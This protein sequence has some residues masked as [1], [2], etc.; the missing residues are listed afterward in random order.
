MNIV[1]LEPNNPVLVSLSSP[2]GKIIWEGNVPIEI[3][4]QLTDG[5][6]LHV[7]MEVAPSILNLG[8]FE[9]EHFFICRYHS[10][11]R[12]VKDRINVWLTNEGEKMRAKLERE[13]SS[14]NGPDSQLE[15]QLAGSLQQA[16]ERK[17]PAA[18]APTPITVAPK[19]PAS[20]TVPAA[21]APLYARILGDTKQLLNVYSEA[22]VHAESL[23]VPAGVVRSLMLSAYISANQRGGRAA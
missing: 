21:L 7:P 15:R 14:A 18:P 22:I 6:S 4:Y 13:E 3:R 11:D 5:R 10:A 17:E 23:G 12:K 9:K 16:K 20:A 19:P 8:L 1:N 2:D